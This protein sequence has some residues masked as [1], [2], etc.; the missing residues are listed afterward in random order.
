VKK[1]KELGEN[2]KAD[3]ENNEKSFSRRE[4]KPPDL[5]ERGQYRAWGE[6]TRLLCAAELEGQMERGKCRREEEGAI[7]TH[8]DE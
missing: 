7:S 6:E 5:K 8:H 3:S 1:R 2:S 4:I